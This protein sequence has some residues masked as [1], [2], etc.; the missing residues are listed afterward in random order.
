MATVTSM[1]GS[2]GHCHYPEQTDTLHIV[3]G[4]LSHSSLLAL[5]SEELGGGGRGDPSIQVTGQQEKLSKD[6]GKDFLQG[7]VIKLPG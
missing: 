7:N 5:D 6:E 4:P 2:W 1:P 3:P